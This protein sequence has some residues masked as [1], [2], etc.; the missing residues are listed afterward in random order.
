MSSW[1]PVADLR[2]RDRRL[3]GL[4][5]AGSEERLAGLADL[6]G[7][8]VEQLLRELHDPDGGVERRDVAEA[9]DLGVQRRVDLRVRLPDRDG[10]DAAEEVEV[11]APVEIL[12]PRAL[13]LVE[14][15]R[16]LVERADAR[17]EELLVLRPELRTRPLSIAHLRVSPRES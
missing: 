4:G 6:A 15:D 14:A 8:E 3:V 17:E 7:R 1:R 2:E 11:L 9:V 10:Q 12:E 5:A 13:A 16:L